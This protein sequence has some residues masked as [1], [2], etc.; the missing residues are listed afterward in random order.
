VI[1]PRQLT[2]LDDDY[3][4]GLRALPSPPPVISVAG[5]IEPGPAVAIVG[6][7]KPTRLAARL[8]HD[9]ASAI[10]ARGTIVISGGAVGIDAA[11][12][13]G[14]M[15]GGGRTWVVSGTGEGVL[16]PKEHGPLF[17]RI[18][19]R[20]GAMVWPFPPGTQGHRHTFLQ[21]NGVLVA[22]AQLVV[23]VQARIPSG[24]LN[25]ALWARRLERPRWVVCPA[26]WEAEGFEGCEAEAAA[27]AHILTS[28][29]R[30]LKESGIPFGVS[31]VRAPPPMNPQ[32]QQVLAAIDRTPRHV[33]EVA[34]KCRLPYSEV[35]TALLT[36]GLENV[37]VEGP[38]GFYRRAISP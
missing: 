36:L 8:A 35:M 9:L 5:K 20:G 4:L 32:Q 23:I 11:A 3:P 31:P 27:G 25:A 12:H 16:Y 18:V 2:P 17:A 14:A 34:G 22:L 33:D 24:A 28:V 10:A 30:F 21:R 7:R 6:T 13:E 37:V 29:P 38:E 19:E 15:A 26:P 1:G